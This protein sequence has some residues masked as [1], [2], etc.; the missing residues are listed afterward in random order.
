MTQ[1]SLSPPNA[2]GLP[3]ADQLK[4]QTWD[5]HTEAE[6]TGFINDILRGKA[7]LAHYILFMQNLALVYDTMESAYDWLET[8]PQLKPYIGQDI[9]RADSIR[10]DLKHLSE[11]S[12]SLPVESIFP[13]T[14]AYTEAIHKALSQN[15]PA[16][17]AHIYVRYLGD[18]N[19]GLVLQRL[20]AKNLKL[21]ANCL[22]FYRFPRIADLDEFKIGFR[23]AINQISLSEEGRIRAVNAAKDAFSYNIALSKALK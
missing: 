10:R 2:L 23:N 18:V 4:K 19:G 6:T 13:T 21:P 14:Q 15:H 8:C 7:T 11:F 20:L 5:L 16:M 12:V 3:L 9:A 17:I 1:I 22:S